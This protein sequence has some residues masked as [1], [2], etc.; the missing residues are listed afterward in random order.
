MD[1]NLLNRDNNHLLLFQRQSPCK[2][3]AAV[4][5]QCQKEANC[6]SMQWSKINW[7]LSGQTIEMLDGLFFL[8][9]QLHI[10][11]FSIA[12]S[13]IGQAR[14]VW[15]WVLS[16]CIAVG[17]RVIMMLQGAISNDLCELT[18]NYQIQW[19]CIW[20]LW[21]AWSVYVEGVSTDWNTMN[22]VINNNKK[23]PPK[24]TLE[25]LSCDWLSPEEDWQLHKLSSD[26][27]CKLWSANTCSEY[28]LTEMFITIS[29]AQE[30]VNQKWFQLTFEKAD[31]QHIQKTVTHTSQTARD[32]KW[33]AAEA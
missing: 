21:H 30:K 22:S 15:L 23:S 4:P 24:N 27:Y 20:C 14:Q 28:V 18:I 5:E 12:L 16:K 7:G 31:E 25:V 19:C 3:W 33:S 1:W 11:H 8:L 6:I 29:A 26:L 32:G 2:A 17:S 10:L 13:T 9:K